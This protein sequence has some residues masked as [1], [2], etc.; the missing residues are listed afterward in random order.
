MMKVILLKDVKSLGNKDDIVNVSDGYGR[1]YLLPRNYAV[2]AT[3]GKMD[4]IEKKNIAG[5]NK[6]ARELNEAKE[7]AKKI[8]KLEVEMRTK[9]GSS[10][11][12]FG[13]ITNKDISD[14]IKAQ[15]KLDIDKKKIIINEAIKTLGVHEIEIKVYP[16]VTAKIKVKVV[17]E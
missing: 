17:E 10:G 4:E 6:K 11:K 15:H 3:P 2:E 1:N 13:S 8:N 12:L 7:L 14:M 5:A 16:E 9:A